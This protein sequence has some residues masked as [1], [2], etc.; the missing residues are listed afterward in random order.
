MKKFLLILLC[1]LA[2]AVPVSATEAPTEMTEPPTLPPLVVGVRT[3]SEIPESWNPLEVH[4]DD[5]KAML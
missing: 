5:Q 1:L 3:L 4:S 2:L